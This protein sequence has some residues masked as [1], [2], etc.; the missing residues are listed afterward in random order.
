M[1]EAMEPTQTATGASADQSPITPEELAP[2][3]QQLEILD[4]LGRGGMGVVYKARQKSLNRTVALKLIAPE[5]IADEGFADRFTLEARALASLNHPNIVTVHDFG[6][7]GGF[8]YLLMEFVDGVNLRQAMKAGHFTPEQ[9]LAVIPPV[10]EA[11]QCAHDHGIVHRDIKPENLLLDKEGR[12]KIADFGIAKMLHA[13]GAET[14]VTESQPAGT[15][16]YMAPEQKDTRGVDH[17]ADIYSLGV[18]LYELLTGELP[19]QNLQPPSKKI[20]IDVRLDEIVLKALDASPEFRFQTA[21]ELRT[22]VETMVGESPQRQT[23]RPKDKRPRLIRSG[24]SMLTTKED[25]ATTSGQM[26]CVRTRGQLLLDDNYLTH[27]KNGVSTSIPLNSIRDLSIG[28]FPR[29]V[30]PAGLDLICVTYEEEGQLKQVI[31]SPHQSIFS[32]PG[33]Y[34]ANLGEWFR[35]IGDAVEDASGTRPNCTPSDQLDLPKGTKGMLAFYLAAPFMIPLPLIFFLTLKAGEG[36]TPWRL[37]VI[38]GAFIVIGT[39]IFLWLLTSKSQPQS[40]IRQRSKTH[41][42]VMVLPLLVI[43]L[44]VL[45]NSR[46]LSSRSP[47]SLSSNPPGAEQV[48]AIPASLFPKGAH[49][50]GVDHSVLVIHNDADVHYVFYHS[51]DFN[52]SSSGTR[53][54]ATGSW[55]DK[56]SIELKNERSFGYLRSALYPD[57]LNINGVDYDLREGRIFIL[58]DD[59]TVT[60]NPRPI[61][62]RDARTPERMGQLLAP[63]TKTPVEKPQ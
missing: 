19:T 40:D 51:G 10:C 13:E 38:V 26:F 57:E 30:N 32:T 28:M 44:F 14:D 46:F 1:A 3:F 43:A 60:P 55:E 24:F 33:T 56:G 2:F 37:P 5:K 8:Y 4:Y 9:A 23:N 25:L 16:Q 45:L 52:S 21:Q 36:S 22:Q 50:G 47:A 58:N 7:A 39:G 12:I 61:S 20:Q 63:E 27:S 54:T 53:N 29:T 18:V 59:G 62:L 42:A 49:I 35:V 11:M 34:N 6:Q 48:R 15:P 31:L 41:K 17:R